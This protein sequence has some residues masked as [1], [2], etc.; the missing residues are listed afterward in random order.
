MESMKK[1][2]QTGGM[3]PERQGCLLDAT[4]E[5]AS[6]E[7]GF[8]LRT[9]GIGVNETRLQY[10]YFGKDFGGSFIFAGLGGL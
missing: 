7:T 2:V 9:R 1:P 4:P 10:P 3:R 5:P 8:D 6:L